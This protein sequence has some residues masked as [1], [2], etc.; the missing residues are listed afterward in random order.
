MP[1]TVAIVED[2]RDVRESIAALI[3]SSDGF[4]C[5]GLFENAED[6][7][8]AIPGLSPDV[9]LMDIHLPGNSGIECIRSL[10]P[11]CPATQF[12]I[13][14]VFEES[15]KI[16]S[17]LE[18]GATGYLLKSTPPARLLDAIREVHDGG[19]PMSSQIA[20]TVVQRFQ[21][22]KESDEWQKL[23]SREQEIL[24]LLSQGFRY[25]EIADKLFI[26][27][28]TVRTHIRNIYEKLQVQSRTDALNK[29]FKR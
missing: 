19:S 5:L 24:Q 23:T 16:F 7:T 1:L 26:S 11:L 22:K 28:E 21:H 3:S 10:K 9:V 20:R 25:K 6:A 14:T 4:A 12:V 29:V 13:C 17:A 18:A 27:V 2:L 15:D 8:E